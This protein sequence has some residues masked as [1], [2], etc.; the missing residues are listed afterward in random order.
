MSPQKL[1]SF[2][3]PHIFLLII[4]HAKNHV[5]KQIASFNTFIKYLIL[6]RPIPNPQN[7]YVFSSYRNPIYRQTKWSLIG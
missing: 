2:Y 3:R 4:P 6:V 5:M 1:S 7:L